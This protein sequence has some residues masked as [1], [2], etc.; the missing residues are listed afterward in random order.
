[1]TKIAAKF[2]SFSG[3]GPSL[4]MFWPEGQSREQ[5]PFFSEK[6]LDHVV[7]HLIARSY[8]N[9]T[10]GGAPYYDGS[11][12]TWNSFINYLTEEQPALVGLANSVRAWEG[13][14]FKK[15]PDQREPQW[16]SEG[17][18]VPGT[19]TELRALRQAYLRFK[20]HVLLGDRPVDEEGF[21]KNLV[22]FIN[23]DGENATNALGAVIPA[24][25]QNGYFTPVDLSSAPVPDDGTYEPPMRYKPEVLSTAIEFTADGDL[26]AKRVFKVTKAAEE[27]GTLTS[28]VSATVDATG[29][30]RPNDKC[31]AIL[32]TEDK[33]L[34][35]WFKKASENPENYPRKFIQTLRQRQMPPVARE[36]LADVAENE[37]RLLKWAGVF[38]LHIKD[39]QESDVA[40]VREVMKQDP[41][42]E[43]IV[44]CLSMA[45]ALQKEGSAVLSAGVVRSYDDVLEV[46]RSKKFKLEC[47]SILQWRS[48][49][50]SSAEIDDKIT[51][52][53]HQL[54]ALYI[55]AN[56][57]EAARPT[58]QNLC[59]QAESAL[60][61]KKFFLE[62]NRLLEKTQEQGRADLVGQK[63]A[64]V[65]SMTTDI[66]DLSRIFTEIMSK[67]CL[68][69][70]DKVRIEARYM[71]C[72][73]ELLRARRALVIDLIK[74]V[75]ADIL[76]GIRSDNANAAVLESLRVLS[77]ELESADRDAL[78]SA[79]QQ[80]LDWF[81]KFAQGEV[82][83]Q[84]LPVL[85]SDPA[86]YQV[87]AVYKYAL[88][89][90]ESVKP[91][92]ASSAVSILRD[93]EKYS[94]SRENDA[95]RSQFMQVRNV[96]VNE[97]GGSQ[98]TCPSGAASAAAA[99]SPQA[100]NETPVR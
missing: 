64:E 75:A 96:V 92:A 80:F 58:F 35:E 36:L 13:E 9:L 74:G 68:Q 45:L 90:K 5:R 48:P 33:Q 40:L 43:H 59:H 65:L 27:C 56:F 32:N 52:L 50:K 22:I 73:R 70:R 3:V 91:E 98:I 41:A 12:A 1:M 37:A 79:E 46:C 94:V 100:P 26:L 7:N 93:L 8:S 95:I 57:S 83:L 38:L 84:N 55:P 42:C 30:L 69:P 47:E 6:M 28:E 78:S 21:F 63:E 89:L 88:S 31:R 67:D 34:E 4:A 2:S 19:V 97:L 16:L 54:A 11:D 29:R 49:E 62:S 44:T 86:L 76:R 82:G 23:D 72:A 14:N 18:G 53:H 10:I 51:N 87:M 17:S 85:K 81:S 71:S 20:V 60:Y 15:D 24:F 66:R 39:L 77:G 99:T 61:V 25:F